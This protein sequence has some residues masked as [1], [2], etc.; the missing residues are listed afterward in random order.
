MRRRE[1]IMLAGWTSVAWP[2]AVRAQQPSRVPTVGF[3]SPNSKAAAN[4][5]TAAFVQGLQ[6]RGW[7]EDQS[8][9][10]KYRWEDGQVERTSELVNELIQ[11]KVDV[12]VTHGVPNIVAA[13]KATP[14]V[15]SSSRWQR[16]RSAAVLLP[17]LRGR[18]GMSRDCRLC[19]ATWQASGW[20]SAPTGCHGRSQC[21]PILGDE[22]SSG[23]RDFG[24]S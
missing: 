11:L 10:I 14:T 6:D 12:I 2:L 20:S 19:R 17:V 9:I 8:V 4:A 13:M 21:I 22:R 23:P 24:Q 16:T 15:R 18:A 3:L 5:W 7:I 1:F